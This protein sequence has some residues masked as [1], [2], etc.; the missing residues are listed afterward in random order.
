MLIEDLFEVSKANSGN[1][2]MHFMDADI[3]NLMK[4]VRVELDDRIKESTLDFRWKLPEEKIL[5]SLDGQRTYRIFENLINNAIKYAM[6]YTR[7]YVEMT[8]EASEVIITFK[9]MSAQELSMD[10]DDL[11]ERFVRGDSARQSEGSGLGLAI[12]KSFTELQ[13]GSFAIKV[14]GDLF[15]VTLTFPKNKI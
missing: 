7:V 9:N 14:D 4:E 13:N 11:T 1:V 10:A 6:P 8:E 3:V 2:T 15:K 12:A 5:V